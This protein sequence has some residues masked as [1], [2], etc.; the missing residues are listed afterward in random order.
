MIC[1]ETDLIKSLLRS[2]LKSERSGLAN[3]LYRDGSD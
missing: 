1:V 2:F 3:D